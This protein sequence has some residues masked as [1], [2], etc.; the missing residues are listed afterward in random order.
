MTARPRARREERKHGGLWGYVNAAI[1]G[2]R[3]LY[4]DSLPAT[5][6]RPRTVGGLFVGGLALTGL[7]YVRAPTAFIPNE[8]VGYFIATVQSPDGS[9]LPYTSN[10][11]LGVDHSANAQERA[12]HHVLPGLT[13]LDHV[14]CLGAGGARCHHRQSRQKQAFENQLAAQAGRTRAQGGADGELILPGRG[15]SQ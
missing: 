4:H 12:G 9:S 14:D 1:D 10:V 15:T 6:R 2:T 11:A 5:L 3:R 8:D 13:R 7:M